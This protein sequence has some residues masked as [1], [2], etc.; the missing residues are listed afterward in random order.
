MQCLLHRE[1]LVQYCLLIQHKLEKTLSSCLWT[2]YLEVWWAENK[3]KPCIMHDI[4]A[5]KASY[6]SPL[7]VQKIEWMRSVIWP[8]SFMLQHAWRLWTR[9]DIAM[10]CQGSVIVNHYQQL[11]TKWLSYS[12][13]TSWNLKTSWLLFFLLVRSCIIF[14]ASTTSTLVKF[15]PPCRT[16]RASLRRSSAP[17][18]LLSSD[19]T[20]KSQ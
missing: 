10:Q 16:L 13:L 1:I 8:D 18:I 3:R 6:Q 5:A 12:I 14:I 20:C 15:S 4:F 7:L 17:I 11:F 2:V 9:Q 19:W